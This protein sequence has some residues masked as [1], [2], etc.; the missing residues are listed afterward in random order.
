MDYLNLCRRLIQIEDKRIPDY[1]DKE[2]VEEFKVHKE[3]F[4]YALINP[5]TSL[6]HHLELPKTLG[7]ELKT[8][9]V[10]EHGYLPET[11]ETSVADICL[12]VY[13]RE[14]P[15][16]TNLKVIS[17]GYEIFH[18]NNIQPDTFYRIK[19]EGCRGFP[20][21]AT[22]RHQLVIQVYDDKFESIKDKGT[23]EVYALCEN[24]FDRKLRKDMCMGVKNYT[25]QFLSPDNGKLMLYQTALGNPTC[26]CIQN[27]FPKR[28][29]YTKSCI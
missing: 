8:D 16:N 26:Y 23:V 21:I 28:T 4:K 15:L 20:L 1:S 29:Y 6:R 24:E 27:N 14:I 7:E 3:L 19:L 25:H 12:G 9:L 22:I 18:W 11:F 13:V 10:K 17:N 5:E 2:L